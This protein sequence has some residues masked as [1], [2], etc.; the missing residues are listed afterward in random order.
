MSRRGMAGLRVCGFAFAFVLTWV[1]VGGAQNVLQF[2]PP[3]P[4]YTLGGFRYKPPLFD[5]WRQLANATQYLQLMYIE[6]PEEGKLDTRFAVIYEVHEIPPEAEVRDAAS[7][8]EISRRQM[9]E[10]RKPDLVGVSPIAPVPGT[11]VDMYTYR[12]LTKAPPEVGHNV[13]EV[14]YVAIS[15]DQKQYLVIQCITKSETYENELYFQ[16][17]Y[18]SLADLTFPEAESPAAP[19]PSAEGES[20]GKPNDAGQ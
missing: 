14:Y 20:A 6:S 5:G 13:Y 11:K 16:Q 9:G 18:A 7:L 8:A 3:K 12:F 19:S 1:C 17:F 4:E 10:K 2:D 15:A